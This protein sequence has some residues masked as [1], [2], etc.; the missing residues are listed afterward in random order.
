MHFFA[1]IIIPP[2]IPLNN[3]ADDLDV[4]IEKTM[5]SGYENMYDWYQLGG[6]WT[7][8]W[9]TYKPEKDE[10]NWEACDLCDADGMRR[11]LDGGTATIC[12]ACGGDKTRLKWPTSWAP[13]IL[14]MQPARHLLNS[15][16]DVPYYVVT[17]SGEWE[18]FSDDSYSPLNPDETEAARELR[19]Q[20]S[21]RAAREA[22]NTLLK[23]YP[24]THLQVIDCHI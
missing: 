4:Y 19:D 16:L 24:D 12:N 15:T 14:D 17:P 7:G 22:F 21:K 2:A 8:I 11:D 20:D 13:S 18:E 1:A 23:K 9:S 5:E 3:D 6:R 10:N